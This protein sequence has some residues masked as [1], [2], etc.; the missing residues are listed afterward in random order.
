MALTDRMVAES[1]DRVKD[2][3]PEVVGWREWVRRMAGSIRSVYLDRPAIAVLAASR[4]AASPAETTSVEQLIRVLHSA[5]LPVL[6]AAE[7]YRALVDLALAFTQYTAAFALLDPEVQAK[8]E[9]AW[10]VTYAT[11]PEDRF[12]LLHESAPR[13]AELGRDDHAVFVFALDTFLD[14]IEVRIARHAAAAG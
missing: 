14:G 8:D 2:V 11:L 6:E 10:A 1:V 9:R 12:P 13:L 7:T 5:G 4:T 3:D